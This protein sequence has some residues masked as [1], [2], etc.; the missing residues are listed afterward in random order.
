MTAAQGALAEERARGEKSPT[1]AYYHSNA[2]VPEDLP[3]CFERN[4]EGM[5]KNMAI[6]GAEVVKPWL[7]SGFASALVD[8][9]HAPH[10]SPPP[11]NH[12][13]LNAAQSWRCWRRSTA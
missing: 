5:L 2:Y 1:T 13:P 4:S 11:L 6:H 9:W 3:E 10:L 8:H 7:F 12:A